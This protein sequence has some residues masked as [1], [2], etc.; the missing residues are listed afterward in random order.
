M[1]NLSPITTARTTTATNDMVV[2]NMLMLI[3]NILPHKTCMKPG[4]RIFDKGAK[5]VFFASTYGPPTLVDFYIYVELN[6]NIIIECAC[7]SVAY[8]AI[9]ME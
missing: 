8:K 2:Q 3:D 5:N 1:F 7:E 9:K 6:K 4:G